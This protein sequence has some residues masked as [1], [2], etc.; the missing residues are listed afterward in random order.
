MQLRK[1]QQQQHMIQQQQQQQQQQYQLQQRQL[2]LAQMRLAQR[3]S[4]PLSPSSPDF[5]HLQYYQEQLMALEK[6]NRKR[7]MMQRA[8]QQR[9]QTAPVVEESMS[10]RDVV[11]RKTS[12]L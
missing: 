12:K 3:P 1:M 2:Q 9:I 4:S 8:Q 10:Q 5:N 7:L 6:Q 11:K